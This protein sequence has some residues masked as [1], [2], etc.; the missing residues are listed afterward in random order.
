[1]SFELISILLIERNARREYFGTNFHEQWGRKVGRE[2]GNL[3]LT[4][5]G[6]E[7]TLTNQL[8][9]TCIT[10]SIYI[11]VNVLVANVRVGMF[12]LASKALFFKP[13][14]RVWIEH[15]PQIVILFLT[16]LTTSDSSP[17]LNGPFFFFF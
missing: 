1:M 8:Q 3:G 7:V 15:D 5:R 11:E 14:S 6:S 16:S 4:D 17:Y 10:V 13:K 12:I 9:S 2:C